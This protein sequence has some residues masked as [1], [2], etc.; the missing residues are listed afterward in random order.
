VWEDKK[1]KEYLISGKISEDMCCIL[2]TK[3]ISFELK[4]QNNGEK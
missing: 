2:N 4:V 3:E 1:K